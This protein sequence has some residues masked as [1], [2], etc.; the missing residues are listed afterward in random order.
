MLYINKGD[1]SYNE[2][3]E[4][5]K[6]SKSTLIREVKKRKIEAHHKL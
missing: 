4:I 2:V 1:Y 5:T 3:A 6:I